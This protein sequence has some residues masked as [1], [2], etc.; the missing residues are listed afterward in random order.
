MKFL[1]AEIFG[2]FMCEPVMGEHYI[3]CIV[4]YTEVL[5]QWQWV[6]TVIGLLWCTYW[7]LSI[8]VVCYL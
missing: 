4:L 7:P 6:S 5:Q 3:M 2:T 1:Q 8:R